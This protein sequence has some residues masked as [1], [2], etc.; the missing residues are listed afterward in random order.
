[1]EETE[2]LIPLTPEEIQFIKLKI[3]KA[4]RNHRDWDAI[5][6]I[7]ENRIV[8][9]ARPENED[10][11]K[12]YSVDDVL[13]E[14]GALHVFSTVQECQDFLKQYGSLRFGKTLTIGTISFVTVVRISESNKIAVVMDAAH[15]VN[16]SVL[17]IYP[18]EGRLAVFNVD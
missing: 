6:E 3:G 12:A 13:K 5:K 17:G 14:N 10:F 15:P 1:M 4:K 16:G 9:T 18:D 7:L 2:E 8:Y 11:R